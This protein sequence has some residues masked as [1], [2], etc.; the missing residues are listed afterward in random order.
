MTAWKGFPFFGLVILSSLQ[1]IPEDL[2]EAA[3]VDARGSAT[4]V[5]CHNAPGAG[6]DTVTPDGVG[7][8]VLVPAVLP[9]ILST[10]GGPGTDTSTLSLLIY[11]QAFTFYNY[12]YASALA[13][14]GL[15]IA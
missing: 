4:A 13:V 1:S 2:Y 9:H 6:P 14:V 8:C 5:S 3:D 11:N 12:D 7:V 15:I 10:G